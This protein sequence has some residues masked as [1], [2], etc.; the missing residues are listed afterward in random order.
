MSADYNIASGEA[1]DQVRLLISDVGGSSGS[2]FLFTNAEIEFFLSEREQNVPLAAAM[3]LRTIAS[4]EAMVS[5]RIKFLE[6]ETD[7]PDVGEFL[8]KAAKALEEQADE[9]FD[10]EVFSMNVDLFSR[11]DILREK[12]E[13]QG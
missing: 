4:N 2:D 7:G 3:A 12:A 6:L 13:R 11:R 1:K 8:L 5:K 9:D 10:F